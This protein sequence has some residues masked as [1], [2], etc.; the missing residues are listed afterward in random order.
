MTMEAREL[1][2]LNL[3]DAAPWIWA[4]GGGLAGRVMWHAK[5]V[6]MGKRKALS[7]ALFFDL[8]IAL[9]MGFIAHSLASYLGIAGDA[10]VMIT[11][12]A[13]YLGP[14]II[15]RV[16]AASFD[17]KFGKGTSE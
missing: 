15:D 8:P 10:E 11:I 2:H 7:W 9:G 5:Q 17:W 16:A 12:S 14:Y 3:Q 13:G 4:G 6:Q 1:D